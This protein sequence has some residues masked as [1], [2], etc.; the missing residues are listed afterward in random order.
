[1]SQNPLN[2]LTVKETAEYLR[3]PVPTVYYLVQRGQLPAVQIGGRWRIKKDRLDEEVLK[4][5]G[6]IAKEPETNSAN[7]LVIDDQKDILDLLY[8][9]LSNKGYSTDVGMNGEEALKKLK[10]KTYDLLFLDLN[11]PDITGDEIFEKAVEIQPKIHVVIMTG[12]STVQ[13][14]ERILSCGPV[15]VLQKPFKLEQ[16]LRVTEVI[17]GRAGA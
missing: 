1:M 13:S 12:F 5:K 14:L 7:I 17:L 3:I 8:M 6:V 15:T 4:V 10:E 2:L 11:L 9:A 16:L